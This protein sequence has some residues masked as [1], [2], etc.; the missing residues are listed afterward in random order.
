MAETNSEGIVEPYRFE[1]TRRNK[2]KVDEETG[3]VSDER[4]VG[5]SDTDSS[6]EWDGQ[7]VETEGWRLHSMLWC[8]CGHCRH[9]PTIRENLCCKELMHVENK[10][11][12]FHCITRNPEFDTVCLTRAVLR[13][14]LVAR[15]DIRRDDLQEPLDNRYLCMYGMSAGC[16]SRSCTRVHG[17]LHNHFL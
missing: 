11:E 12:G 14:A 10:V 1:P 15:N 17:E 4:Q 8:T 16:D 5:D 2:R 9:L 6:Q 3:A 7:D 13:T